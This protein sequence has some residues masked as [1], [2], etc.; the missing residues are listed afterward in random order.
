MVAANDPKAHWAPKIRLVEGGVA[1]LPATFVHTDD[2]GAVGA[3]SE[4]DERLSAEREQAVRGRTPTAMV[5]E[6]ALN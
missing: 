3:K 6:A 5:A 4:G 2:F 1:D